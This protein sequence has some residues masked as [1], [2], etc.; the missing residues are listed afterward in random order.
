MSTGAPPIIINTRAPP[1]DIEGDHIPLSE[2]HPLERGEYI[3]GVVQKVDVPTE[4]GPGVF[5]PE[6]HDEAYDV[7]GGAERD[8]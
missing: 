4:E 2:R 6:D 5:R 7:L 8:Y 3:Q 1:P